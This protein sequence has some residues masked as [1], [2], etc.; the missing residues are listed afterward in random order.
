MMTP[1]KPGRFLCWFHGE[2][3]RRLGSGATNGIPMFP[4]RGKSHASHSCG[5]KARTW[6]RN[7]D[8]R[9]GSTSA[10]S[11][12]LSPGDTVSAPL[13]GICL[14][15]QQ[16]LLLSIYLTWYGERS[17]CYLLL[18]RELLPCWPDWTLQCRPSSTVV[19]D[20]SFAW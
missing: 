5:P 10:L 3:K 9:R 14:F 12:S 17:F 19:E 6:L 4:G 16:H 8:V 15:F 7:C 1:R 18:F 13:R 2:R 20:L 11:L